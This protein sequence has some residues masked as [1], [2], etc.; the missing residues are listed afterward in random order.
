MSACADLTKK[1]VSMYLHILVSISQLH[2]LNASYIQKNNNCFTYAIILNINGLVLQI[3]EQDCE[4]LGKVFR[5][6]MWQVTEFRQEFKS[7]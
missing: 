5:S 7:I 6:Q 1:Y 2:I 3:M 4:D